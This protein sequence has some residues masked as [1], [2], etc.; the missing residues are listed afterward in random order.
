[1]QDIR[2]CVESA[3]VIANVPQPDGNG[4]PTAPNAI[5]TDHVV[6]VAHLILSR[7][8]PVAHADDSMIWMTW[9]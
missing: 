2:R 1:M 3:V 5:H 9:F 4:S 8:H 7:L 6:V